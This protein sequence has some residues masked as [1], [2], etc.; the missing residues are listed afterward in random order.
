MTYCI[1]LKVICL[2]SRWTYATEDELGGSSHW[3][4]IDTYGGGGY[5]QNLGSRRDRAESMVEEIKDGL[6]IARG[7]RVVFLDFTVYNANINLFCVVRYALKHN[8]YR[9]ASVKSGSL[10]VCEGATR[11]QMCGITHF[12]M[13]ASWVM[14]SVRHI[15]LN[16]TCI[17]VCD[18][19]FNLYVSLT[20]PWSAAGW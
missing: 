3:G 11:G 14:Y 18:L 10:S 4:L 13:H 2:L 17:S 6:W 15:R 12:K 5:V 8:M 7:T 1:L 16:L 9:C 19:Y 20:S